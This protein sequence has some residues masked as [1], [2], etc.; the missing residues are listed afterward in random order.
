MIYTVDY[1]I[2]MPQVEKMPANLFRR[3]RISQIN[4]RFNKLVNKW[5]MRSVAAISA[6]PMGD[7][8]SDSKKVHSI[9]SVL[10]ITESDFSNFASPIGKPAQVAKLVDVHA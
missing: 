6:N 5:R 2:A 3:F 1:L 4:A 9:D 7:K 8:L 10:Q